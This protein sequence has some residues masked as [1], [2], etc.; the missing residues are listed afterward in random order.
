MSS[1]RLGWKLSVAVVLLAAVLAFSFSI[2]SVNGA[3]YI[4]TFGQTGLDASAIGTVVTVGNSAKTYADLPFIM[5]VDAKAK[6]G[7]VTRT[8]F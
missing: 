1:I 8:L 6:A 7:T 5:M 3:Q 2:A 4:V